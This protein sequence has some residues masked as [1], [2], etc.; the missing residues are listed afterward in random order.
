[1]D[2]TTII[3]TFLRESKMAELGLYY[4]SGYEI[5]AN[6]I[7]IKYKTRLQYKIEV[8]VVKVMLQVQMLCKI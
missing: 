2:P 8:K 5:L 3:V 6:Y 4:L 7:P 1:M